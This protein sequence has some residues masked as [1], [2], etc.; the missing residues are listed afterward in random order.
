MKSMN[1]NRLKLNDLL[2]KNINEI[3]TLS[4]NCRWFLIFIPKRLRIVD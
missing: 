3:K 1:P 4:I 2:S